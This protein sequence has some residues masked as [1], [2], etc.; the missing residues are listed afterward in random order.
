MPAAES[1]LAAMSRVRCKKMMWRRTTRVIETFKFFASEWRKDGVSE[2]TK[3]EVT[4]VEF[5][6][7]RPL[8][9]MAERIFWN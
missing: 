4:C 9:A 3:E 8:P 2:Q 6:R 5:E 7:T 1:A